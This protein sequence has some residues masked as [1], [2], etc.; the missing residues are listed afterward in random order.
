VRFI[1]PVMQRDQIECRR[2]LHG[3]ILGEVFEEAALSFAREYNGEQRR[4]AAAAFHA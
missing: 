2:G 3:V 1:S 4:S